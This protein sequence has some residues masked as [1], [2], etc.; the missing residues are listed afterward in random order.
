MQPGQIYDGFLPGRHPIDAYGDGGFRFAGMSHRGSILILPSGIYA[1]RRDEA[2]EPS[3]AG[4]AADFALIIDKLAAEADEIDYLFIGTG[5]N[6]LL[7]TP[8][9]RSLLSDAGLKHE[10]MQ[11]GAALQTYNMLFDEQ[12]R[13]AAAIIAVNT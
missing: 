4:I 11:S 8:D 7:P 10:A 12:R 1:W 9:L 2:I 13:V 3:A 6:M 5:K